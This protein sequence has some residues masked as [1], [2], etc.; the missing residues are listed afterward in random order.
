VPTLPGPAPSLLPFA[1]HL[2]DLSEEVIRRYFRRPLAVTNKGDGT[3]FDPVTVADRA[4][5]RIMRRAI[6]KQF[7]DHG[8]VGEEFAAVSGAGRYHWILDPIDGTR[9]FMIGSPLWG[10]LIA[11][12]DRGRPLLGL[13]NQPFTRERFWAFGGV[14]RMHGPGG[15]PK[16]L[17]TRPCARLEDAVLTTTHPDLFAT[18][19]ERARFGEIKGRALLTRFGG[20]CYGY[21]L[22][23]AGFVDLV[24]E[25]GLQPYDVMA[26]VPI[27]EYAG[28]VI[29]TWEGEPAL[30]GGRIVAAGDARTH[31]QALRL[32]AD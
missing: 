27:I 10:T 17:K 21:C 5:E 29:T 2:A 14:A 28:G 25:S 11:L 13:M 12:T 16:R 15:R 7:P 26:L 30:K 9:A 18:P 23:A 6:A 1:H 4:A 3:Q 19:V 31:R 32:L 20:D 8:V 24:I 22:L